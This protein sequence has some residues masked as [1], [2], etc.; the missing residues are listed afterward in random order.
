MHSHCSRCHCGSLISNIRSPQPRF[1]DVS[2]LTWGFYKYVWMV[3]PITGILPN[4]VTSGIVALG[5]FLTW[6]NFILPAVH[7][8]SMCIWSNFP[9]IPRNLIY[10]LSK[11]SQPILLSVCVCV[12]FFNFNKKFP[13][14][15][16]LLK[17]QWTA[18][19]NIQV[20]NLTCIFLILSMQ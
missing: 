15:P 9:T 8:R 3:T 16:V 19:H 7:C 6:R 14:W 2:E 12:F 10:W 20:N 17:C 1:S 5:R 11:C 13:L 4:W 18:P